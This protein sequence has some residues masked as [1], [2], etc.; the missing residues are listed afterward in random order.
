VGGYLL[1]RRGPASLAGLALCLA[2]PAAATLAWAAAVHREGDLAVW[3][4]YLRV[5]DLR[6]SLRHY[7]RERIRFA[8]GVPIDLLPSTLLLPSV[9]LVWWRAARTGAGQAPSPILPPLTFYAGLCTLVLLAW[10]GTKTRYAMPIAPAVS[11][12]A[13]LAFGPLARRRRWEAALALVVGAGLLVYQAALVAVATPLMAEKLGAPRRRGGD[14]DAVIGQAPAPVFTLG[15]PQSNR[16][17]YVSYPIRV[18]APGEAP[19][20]VPAWV[21]ARRSELGSVPLLGSDLAVH[22]VDRAVTGP[23]LVLVRIERRR[24]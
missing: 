23:G 15:K 6:F 19:I 20:P 13:A 18:I 22:E 1:F 14:I 16:L 2:L 8:V 5:H 3:F 4:H 11:V 9:L 17:V 21:F 10:P 7:L 12:M 24:P